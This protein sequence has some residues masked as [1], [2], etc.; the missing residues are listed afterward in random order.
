MNTHNTPYDPP[1]PFAPY[2]P[3]SLFD[4]PDGGPPAP[5]A[6]SV[7]PVRPMES[8]PSAEQSVPTES[9]PP[10]E[11]FTPLEPAEPPIP[12]QPPAE[13]DGAWQD[14]AFPEPPFDFRMAPPP[15]YAAAL[16]PYA[17]S[18]PSAP[19]EYHAPAQPKKRTRAFLPLIALC[20]CFTLIGGALG[21]YLVLSLYKPPAAAAEAPHDNTA[22]TGTF[23]DGAN[24]GGAAQDSGGQD[25]AV[26]PIIYQPGSEMTPAQ[27][28]EQCNAGVVAIATETAAY[29]VFGRTVTQPAA[30]SGF[31]ISEDGYI[32]TNNHVIGGASSIKVMLSTGDT[33]DAKQIGR[34]ATNDL[35]VLKIEAAGLTALS[36]GASSS[37]AV[38]DPIVAIGNPL[39]ELANSATSGIVSALDRSIDMDGTPMTYLQIDASVSPGNSGGP[40]FDRYGYVVGVVSAKSSGSGVEGIGFAIPSEIAHSTVEQLIRHGYV[41]GRPQLGISIRAVDETMA[42]YYNLPVGVYVVSVE[43]D[44]CAEKAGLQ[45]GD[46]VIAFGGV[47][48]VTQADLV[49]QKNAHKAGETVDVT[50]VRAGNEVTLHITLDEAQADADSP[51]Q[52]Q[53]DWMTPPW[54]QQ[55]R[56][57]EM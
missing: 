33:Y 52:E 3:E 41:T 34:D 18:P 29:N 7:T 4:S 35:A 20:L 47:K 53:D 30:G 36:W 26:Q 56:D 25:S 37:L 54:M 57:E 38:G 28:F 15:S 11:P 24:A 51:A 44:S 14:E 40:L 19:L 43:P 49:G 50:V 5:S 2:D 13:P 39:G 10:A 16:Q 9:A 17:S 27:I 1:E 32:V 6:E 12:S 55:Q 45:T 48:V 23:S 31:I 42:R 21:G 8:F 22:S 46:V